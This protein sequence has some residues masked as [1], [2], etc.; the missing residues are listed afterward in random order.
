MTFGFLEI[1]VHLT[2]PPTSYS[3]LCRLCH[4]L[5]RYLTSSF[6]TILITMATRGCQVQYSPGGRLIFTLFFV[7]LFWSSPTPERDTRPFSCY[8]FLS[9]IIEAEIILSECRRVSMTHISSSECACIY[10]NFLCQRRRVCMQQVT[11]YVC[12][13]VEC[14]L[15][16]DSRNCYASLVSTSVREYIWAPSLFD[17]RC[18]TDGIEFARLFLLFF[19]FCSKVAAIRTKTAKRPKIIH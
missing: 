9:A 14:I 5:P 18:L 2:H 15:Q 13:C 19:F 10:S 7:V 3:S 11:Q 16:A 4:S 6:A 8:S 12:T 1:C 17:V